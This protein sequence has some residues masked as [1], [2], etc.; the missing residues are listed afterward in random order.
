MKKKYVLYLGNVQ[1]TFHVWMNEKLVEGADQVLKKVEITEFLKE[2]D[3]EILVE[4]VS[5]LYNCL[6]GTGEKDVVPFQVPYVEKDYGIWEEGEERCV[7][8]EE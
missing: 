8:R 5:N 4:V 2:G 7:V 1:D 3:N 6:Q